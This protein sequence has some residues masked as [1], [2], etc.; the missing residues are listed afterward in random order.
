MKITVNESKTN[1]NKRIKDKK[2]AI[3]TTNQI[4]F[5]KKISK[6]EF[7]EAIATY[8]KKRAMQFYQESLCMPAEGDTILRGFTRRKEAFL[9]CSTTQIQD[10]L[11][12]KLTGSRLYQYIT[13][14]ALPKQGELLKEI[15]ITQSHNWPT[16]LKRVYFAQ[17]FNSLLDELKSPESVIEH[18]LKSLNGVAKPNTVT[19]GVEFLVSLWDKGW[20]AL[21]SSMYGWKSNRKWK[22][23]TS[24]LY[25][26]QKSKY[27]NRVCTPDISTRITSVNLTYLFFAISNVETSN[28]ISPALITSFEDYL[29]TIGGETIKLVDYRRASY[30]G[31]TL[32]HLIAIHN[33]ENPQNPTLR[34]KARR[35]QKN[36]E[37]RR[38][39]G[40]FR[41]LSTKR[42][43]L[44]EWVG[45]LSDF[46]F[47]SG[48]TRAYS[49]VERLNAFG[50]YLCTLPCPPEHPLLVTR[51]QHIKDA[52]LKNK[53]TF[54]A[55]VSSQDWQPQRKAATL[56][57]LR[58]FFDW[59][60][61]YYFA[62]GDKRSHSFANPISIEDG[63]SQRKSNGGQTK[64][65]A[66]PSFI[67]EE[68]KDILTDDDFAFAKRHTTSATTVINNRTGTLDRVFFPGFASSMYLMLEFPF[69]S[70]QT[71]WL[72]SGELDEYIYDAA[73]NSMILNISPFAVAGRSEGVLRLMSDG[74]RAEKWLGIYVNT[75][76]TAIYDGRP[77][78][79]A[80]PYLSEKAAEILT[81]NINWL[82][83]YGTPLSAPIPYFQD[84]GLSRKRTTVIANGPQ[85]AP[86]FREPGETVPISYARLSRFYIK[87]LEETQTRVETK[88]GQK[89]QLVKIVGNETRWIVDLHSLRVSGITAM[90]ESGVP[91][92]IVSE[93]LA[94]HATIAM[95]LHYLKFGPAKVKEY[96]QQ[97]EDARKRTIDIFNDK[98]LLES[99]EEFAPQLIG[100][101]GVGSPTGIHALRECNG[102]FVINPDGI[103]PG[104]SCDTG[105]PLI[106]KL[107]TPVP[108][109]QRC[110]LC[111]HFL[112]GP[113]FLLGQIVSV[114]NLAFSIRK[115]GI[116][117]KELNSKRLDAED[118]G[119]QR[120]ARSLRDRVE[121][122][123]REIQI[124][125]EE[126][127]ARYNYAVQSKELLNDNKS[128]EKNKKKKFP[129]LTQNSMEEL[130]FTLEKIHNFALLDQ[131]TQ[132][133][134][135]VT[136]YT[137]R[138]AFLEKN[139]ILTKMMSENGFRPFLLT[140]PEKE[141][142]E[143][144]N[145]LS[146]ILISQIRS[147]QLEEVLTGERKISDYP[148]IKNAIEFLETATERKN[149]ASLKW[150]SSADILNHASKLSEGKF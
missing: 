107:P 43:E 70:H 119:N 41:W 126:W 75:N 10:V 92:E 34:E 131:I 56:S 103:C 53:L 150:M 97:A 111:R 68:M 39:D 7:K 25:A 67:L 60:K 106:N 69:R 62:N 81:Q 83:I 8:E 98:P 72:D 100:Q 134:E 125:I 118:E 149:P 110:G 51:H 84:F 36:P 135:F 122:L 120:Q 49:I 52:T 132:T 42:Y 104:T 115:K 58:E 148:N 4:L 109:G 139:F 129:I 65:K 140:L 5:L 73:S 38:M 20:I 105:G 127:V 50:D 47:E 145:L 14:L 13:Q 117:I 93:F 55:Y 24:E 141:A 95:T 37:T 74:I 128:N 99:L 22:I 29:N 86:L 45:R 108:G 102:I 30:F 96:L 138:E 124:D 27:I 18:L 82:R 90:I 144:G 35:N 133:H 48:T 147:S 15:C 17:D 78:G 87:L 9:Y 26:P 59:I 142:N 46:V 91:L 33:A 28:E 89:I 11:K 16:R 19:R 44:I 101:E 40:E 61:D 112:T 3:N 32:D 31:H 114:N 79:K 21:P 23:L 71:T 6:M 12:V 143:V 136:G 63:K 54:S 77:Q 76:K 1:G 146:S 123:N 137:N 64:R 121:L 66:L 2:I 57:K 94:T 88:Y 113:S 116:E 80:I 130:Q 85:I